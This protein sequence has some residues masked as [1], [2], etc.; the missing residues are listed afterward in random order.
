MSDTML[1]MSVYRVHGDTMHKSLEEIATVIHSC[2]MSDIE[3]LARIEDVV[4]ETRRCMD[5]YK[6]A[7][8]TEH[9]KV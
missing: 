9:A 4:A 7:R 6:A 3:R 2:G 8:E 5:R 1:R